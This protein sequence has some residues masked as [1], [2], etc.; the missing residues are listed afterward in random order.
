VIMT[1]EQDVDDA[2]RTLETFA[3]KGL[4]LDE[5]TRKLTAEGVKS[6]EDSFVQLMQTIEARRAGVVRRLAERVT[7]HGV[8]MDEAV[9]KAEKETVVARIWSKDASLWKGE[10]EHRKVISNALGWLEVAGGR[11]T[12]SS[13]GRK[14]SAAAS[15][16]P[17]F[18]AWVA[19]ASARRWCA[20]SSADGT[21]TPSCSCS[22][23]QSPKR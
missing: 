19:P 4:S 10:E 1:L 21:V 7:F 9:A 18:S 3:A 20:G 13:P 5:I 2:R 6:F 22:I 11:S 12:L 15:L 16:T 14:R 23:P 8:S 17:S